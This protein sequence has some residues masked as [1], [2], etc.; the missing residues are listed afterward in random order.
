MNIASPYAGAL[1]QA[2]RAR[3]IAERALAVPLNF[4]EADDPHKLARRLLDMVARYDSA[5]GHY[6]HA[7]AMVSG[8]TTS[9]MEGEQDGW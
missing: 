3:D 1:A 7:A 9:D 6:R 8:M 2:R 4:G 5:A